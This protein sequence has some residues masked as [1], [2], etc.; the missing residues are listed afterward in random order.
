MPISGYRTINFVL[1][2][3]I[4]ICITYTLLT[5]QHLKYLACYLAANAKT[6]STYKKMLLPQV[7]VSAAE[8]YD[9]YEPGLLG[10]S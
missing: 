5:T 10:P 1:K 4:Y 2:Y 3:N 9:L 7:S 6:L 8:W